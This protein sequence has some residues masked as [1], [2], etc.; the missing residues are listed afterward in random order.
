MG[1]HGECEKQN[2]AVHMVGG[3]RT[4]KVISVRQKD[5]HKKYIQSFLLSSADAS[6]LSRIDTPI[7]LSHW[8]LVCFLAG[9]TNLVVKLKVEKLLF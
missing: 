4:L 1:E 5:L 9:L 2:K 8:L 3:G 7:Q 6:A